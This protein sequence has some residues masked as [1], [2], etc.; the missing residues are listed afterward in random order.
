MH[1]T[2]DTIAMGWGR[3]LG[4]EI[5]IICTNE[6]K[7]ASSPLCLH[8]FS[9]LSFSLSQAFHHL[10]NPPS[11][12]TLPLTAGP[13]RP[14]RP[15]GCA[16]ARPRPPCHARARGTPP[17]WAR[18][19]GWGCEGTGTKIHSKYWITSSCFLSSPSRSR[20][21]LPYHARRVMVHAAAAPAIAASSHCVSSPC[22]ARASVAHALNT[23]TA[24]DSR[25][26]FKE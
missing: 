5:C 16:A 25:S 14:Q 21:S 1:A 4:V 3:H 23:P 6:L 26:P 9:A 20:L 12:R 18:V 7:K 22:S 11:P 17:H 24:P 13:S 19:G 8:L 10:S 2:S 15:A